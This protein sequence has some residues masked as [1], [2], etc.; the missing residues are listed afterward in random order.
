MLCPCIGG[1]FVMLGYRF[2]RMLNMSHRKFLILITFLAFFTVPLMAYPGKVVQT[3]DAPGKFC[4]G[5]TFDGKFLWVADYKAD[6]LF[7]IDAETGNIVGSISSPAFWPMGLAWDG[8]YLWNADKKRKKIFKI[9]PN[10][11]TILKVID[12]PCGNPEGL[13]WDGETIWVSDS[14]DNKIIKIDLSDGTAVKTLAGP[15]QS[16]T[17]LTYDGRYLWCSDR[18]KDEI[19]MIDPN[20]GDVL[21]ILDA[22]GPYSRGM[23]WDGEYLWNV[24]YEKDKL[25]RLI[26]RDKE[27]Y[28]LKNTRKTMVTFTHQVKVYGKG[29]VKDLQAY[30]AV[31]ENMAQQKIISISFSPSKYKMEK[32]RWLQKIAVFRYEDIPSELTVESIMQVEAEISEIRHFIFPDNCGT[33]DDIP[34]EV[35]K[36]YTANGSKYMTDDPYIQKLAREIAGDEKN[37]YYIARK[38]FDYVGKKLEYKLE[39]GWNAAPVVL[40]RGTGSCSEYSFCFIALCR[41]AGLPARYVGAIVV[42]NDDASMDDVFHRWP[43]VYLPNYGWVTTDAQ[44]GDK[45]SPR[46]KATHFGNLSNRFLITTQG[47]GDSKYLGWY[48]NCNEAYTSDPQVEVNIE[49]FGEWE[50]VL[51][52]AK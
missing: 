30:L 42:R 36:R 48:Y 46:D 7:K 5:M 8:K 11:G 32:D 23:A 27:L 4:T 28:R 24:D 2:R 3:L 51:E 49:A 12:A 25:Y 37:P 21:M 52:E 38:V 29:E 13:A 47:G 17:G 15:A 41:A 22:S 9:D 20:S 35:R 45:P 43:E 16:P 18:M 44:G 6:K 39:G 10:D 14:K 40:K 31:P 19:Y 33:L 26:R 34:S 50:P 1:F